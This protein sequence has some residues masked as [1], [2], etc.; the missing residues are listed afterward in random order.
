MLLIRA[1]GARVRTDLAQ[2][3][4]EIR[5]VIDTLDERRVV[6]GWRLLCVSSY[7]R[8]HVREFNCFD[9]VSRSFV[10]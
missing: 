8:V 6:N 4:G 10:N 5:R 3:E 9:W 7:D 1:P 2:S